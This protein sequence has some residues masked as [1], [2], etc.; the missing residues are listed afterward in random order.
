MTDVKRDDVALGEKG[1]VGSDH[2]PAYDGNNHGDVASGDYDEFSN[3]RDF[4]SMSFWGR[5]GF[6]KESFQRRTE[7]D[8]N[9][10][11]KLNQNMK[12]RH[13]HMIAI[14]GSIGA[15]LFVGTGGALNRGGPMGLILCYMII[16][17]MMF[18]VVFALGE[19]A[20]LYPV[21]GG[22]YVLVTRFV[23]P[24]WGF[25][26]SVPF[27]S[28]YSRTTKIDIIPR[29][30]GTTSCNGFLSCLSKFLLPL[31]QSGIGIRRFTPLCG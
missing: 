2:S 23:D 17:V 19:M 22:F 30:A 5:M 20:M 9:Q 1:V 6:T 12:G 13:L 27:L 24:S 4:N 11:N 16:G 10:H 25:A 7:T 18:N 3:M 8:K 31:S 26:V 15:G 14:G 21:S 29:W 28:M